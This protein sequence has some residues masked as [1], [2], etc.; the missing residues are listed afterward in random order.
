[1]RVRPR[2][3]LLSPL[4]AD[5]S[6]FRA[7][8]LSEGLALPLAFRALG[9]A[10]RSAILKAG[11]LFRAALLA[12]SLRLPLG[13]RAAR[14]RVGRAGCPARRGLGL[15]RSRNRPRDQQNRK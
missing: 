8:L 5:P 6:P 7:R 11:V 10:T 1:M 12:C 9:V 14:W 4:G 13:L 3:E 15:G 2:L